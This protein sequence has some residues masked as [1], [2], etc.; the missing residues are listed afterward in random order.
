MADADK[1]LNPLLAALPP[2][3]DYLTYLTLI[4][5]NLTEE[6]LPILHQVL[7]DP[8]LTANIGWDLVHLLL[9]LLPASEECLQDIAVRGNPREVILKVTEALRLLEFDELEDSSDD[10]ERSEEGVAKKIAAVDIGEFSTSPALLL[11]ANVPPLYVLKFEVL[12][13]L[14]S[15]LHR[16]V[17]T[18]Y[19]SR[20]LSTSLQAVL[21][22]YDKLKHH[23]D[24]LTLSTVKFVKTLSG[25]KRP[26]LPP[27]TAS[28]N[29][30]KRVTSH[31]EPDPEAQRDAPTADENMLSNRLLQSFIT[32]VTE[33]YIVSLTSTDDVPGLAWSSRLME[34]F[35]P[36]RIIPN[37]ATFAERFAEE[38][39]LRTRSAILGQ[40][41]A[42]AQDLGLSTQDLYKTVTEPETERQSI[43]GEEDEPP[44]SADDI[45]L[46]KTG[47]FFLF[48]ARYVKQ[49]LYATAN[50]DKVDELSI[51][52]EHA[53]LLTNF[54]GALGQG[55]I[56]MEPEGTLDAILALALIAMEKNNI[57]ELK[58]DEIFAQYLQSTSM[59][60][61]NC[62]SPSLR[63]HAHYLTS[64]LLRSHP[65]DIVRLTFIKDTLEHCPFANLKTSAVGWLKGETLEAN[66]PQDG[67]NHSLP[68]TST[69]EHDS[70]NDSESHSNIFATPVALSTVS[71]FLFPNL[72]H[73]WAS[74][75]EV[76][77]SWM[78]FRV[79]LGFLLASLNFYYLLLTAKMLHENLDI[80]GLHKNANVEEGFLV[81][82]KSAVVR[83]RKA[84]KE[85]GE[86]RGNEVG[87]ASVSLGDLVLV[88]DVVE[89]VERGIKGLNI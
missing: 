11:A 59:I 13:S 6:N 42:L 63:Y 81:P 76:S 35:E 84:L 58:D 21:V 89:R 70:E 69:T 46:S 49:E 18:K 80:A 31:S 2:A 27:R 53:T 88:D 41:V 61:A 77:E 8:E 32:H 28:G 44:N 17:K 74:A 34:K 85:G 9:P 38:E 48:T 72:T 25:T 40:L 7:S 20:F 62:P 33:D 66:I 47:S 26:H 15:T 86:L 51:F 57:G 52:P 16:R 5:Y 79:D 71:P 78:D 73:S 1:T 29:M 3:T 10:D 23:R 60:S 75:V 4:E 54:V 30:L 68:S 83:F 39:D 43:P 24:E 65:S 37:K 12:L 19:P 87:D 36:R 56:G 45:P 22:A 14:L 55:T 82:L 67:H 64:T 50:A